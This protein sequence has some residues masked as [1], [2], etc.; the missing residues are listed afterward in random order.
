LT[1]FGC[2]GNINYLE[3][4]E[5]PM[6]ASIEDF[7]MEYWLNVIASN[8][9]KKHFK[10]RRAIHIINQEISDSRYNALKKVGGQYCQY[11]LNHHANW[12]EKQLREALS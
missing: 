8:P 5:K 11:L 3:T 2:C 12:I 7:P 1:D 4:K 9:N 10:V 6:L